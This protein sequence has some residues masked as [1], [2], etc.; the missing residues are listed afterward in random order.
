VRPVLLVA[1]P[2]SDPPGTHDRDDAVT[3]E[4]DLVNPSPRRAAN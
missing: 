2:Q 4:L 1:G 3:V